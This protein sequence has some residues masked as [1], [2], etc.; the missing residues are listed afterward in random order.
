[1][2]DYAEL[3]LGLHR[4]DA[5]SY[6]VDLRFQQPGS[7][8]DVRLVDRTP[9]PVRFDQSTFGA[10]DDAAEYGAL[11][12]QSLFADEDV[13][14]TF[15]QALAA[16][17]SQQQTLRLRLFIGPSAP[18]LHGLRWE[19]LRLPG[20]N[21]ADGDAGSAL[22]LGETILFSRYL[23]SQDW[24]PVKLRAETELRA[25][26]VVAGP[27]LSDYPDLAAVDVA[28]EVARAEAGLG[29]IASSVL[30][31]GT[32]DEERVTLNNIISCLR[33]AEHDILYLV[34]HG[35]L[36]DGTPWLW[37]EDEAGDVQRV[38]GVEL[39]TR[40]RELARR[41]RLVVLASCQSAGAT[42]SDGN[43]LVA[44]GPRLAEAGIP[45]VLAMQG[46]ITMETVAELMPTFFRELGRDGQ[47]DRALSVARGAV[48]NRPDWWMPALFLR[49]RS[50]R[51]WYKPGFADEGSGFRKW[52][53]ILANIE[54][55][56]ATPIVGP[57]LSEWIL[58]SQREIAQRWAS[59]YNFP[60]APHD[61]E[62][63]PQVAQFLSV[64]QQPAFPRRELRR[65]L[66]RELLERYG[67]QID[68][69]VAEGDLAEVIAAVGVLHSAEQNAE[70]GDGAG[71]TPHQVLARLN[72]P[73]YITTESTT[74][75][76]D[77]LAA[78]GKQP[79]VELFP[80]NEELEEMD[81]L[82]SPTSGQVNGYVD[83]EP[84]SPQ[85]PLVYHLFGRIDVPGSVVLTQD[86]YF[87]YLAGVTRNKDLIPLRV[88]RALTDTGLLFLGFHLDEWAF[89]VLFHSIIS[90]EGRYR[91]SDYAHVAVQV[92]PEEGRILEPERARQYL[93]S[94]FD[95]DDISIF[96]GNGVDFLR[97]LDRRLG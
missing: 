96:W 26:V 7:E 46:N 68:A 12:G 38:S 71:R 43:A 32:S 91:R 39:V 92:D 9:T 27:D 89:R 88:R 31:S 17:Q 66:K 44:L 2:S 34:C 42:A 35:T 53:A 30:A 47:I 69:G 54:D 29:E 10:L 14:T 87:R 65:Y 23:S 58:G 70:A 62:D 5:D 79:R 63:L 83:D 36:L 72:L 3:E 4:R 18:E 50:G 64:N 93:E 80:W 59:E 75:L 51:I 77:A 52:Q 74:L 73:I 6:L 55:R 49:I 60:M 61:R 97:E 45:A 94:Y 76:A 86:D 67:E 13:R 21:G 25:L 56:T 33:E 48:R 37:L 19:T 16:A 90:R 15:A 28:A 57:G 1:M 8:A 95:A 78:A 41:P 40:L 11:L 22:A 20:H 84:P 24:R 81:A 82:R 85:R